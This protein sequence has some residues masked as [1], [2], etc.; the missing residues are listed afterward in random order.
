MLG[1]EDVRR[2]RLFGDMHGAATD[3]RSATGAG[4]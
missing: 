3:E 4:T 1:V 2:A